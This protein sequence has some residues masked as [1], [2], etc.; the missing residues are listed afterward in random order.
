[1]DKELYNY[2]KE[3]KQYKILSDKEQKELMIKAKLENDQDA[4]LKV[5]HSN[6]LLVVKIA[7]KYYFPFLHLSIMDLIQEGNI[8]LLVAMNNY[9]LKYIDVKKI[10]SYVY[11]T[12][13]RYM[14]VLTKNSGYIIRIPKHKFGELEQ[15]KEKYDLLLKKL[16]RKPTIEELSKELNMT[17]KNVLTLSKLDLIRDVLSI[18][19]EINDEG[20]EIIDFIASKEEDF[21]EKMAKE[22]EENDIIN[23]IF[24]YLTKT[25]ATII[26]LRYGFDGEGYKGHKEVANI[27]GY[28]DRRNVESIER[29]TLKKIKTKLQ[30]WDY[31]NKIEK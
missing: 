8:A 4:F 18:N 15:Y 31:F 24:K 7:Y 17:Y 22:Q 3:I 6:L 25:Q 23:Y 12:I 27:L 5:Y 21:V 11:R 30:D 14:E 20:E 1:M 28:A 10:S 26:N 2:I 9:D 13:D 16:N 19:L 29:A